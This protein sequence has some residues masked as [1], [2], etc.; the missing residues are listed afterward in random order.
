M[1]TTKMIQ[2][3]RSD[4]LLAFFVSQQIGRQIAHHWKIGEKMQAPLTGVSRKEYQLDDPLYQST[5]DT[6]KFA[7]LLCSR[8][9]YDP[10][11]GIGSPISTSKWNAKK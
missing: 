1:F 8:A 3:C 2:Q 7:E 4:N 6:D 5:F 10:T 11:D 9:G